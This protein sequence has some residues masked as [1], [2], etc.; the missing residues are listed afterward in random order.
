MTEGVGLV[1]VNT[2]FKSRPVTGVE[3][4]AQELL[5]RLPSFLDS[6]VVELAPR[7]GADG[8]RGHLWEQVVLPVRFR[9]S[10][11]AV[12]VSLCNFGPLSVSPQVVLLHDV[13]PFLVPDSFGARYA[14]LA[15]TLQ[16]RLAR[17]ATLAT[18]SEQSRRDIAS[19]LGLSPDSIAI[20]PPAAAAP[21]RR[22]DAGPD[23]T[24]CLFVGG[25][26]TRKNLPFLLELW[27]LVHR[28]TGAWLDVVARSRSKTLRSGQSGTSEGIVWHWDIDDAT[29]AG[30]YRK[31]KLIVSPSRYEG[32]GLPLLEAMSCGTPFLSTSV[33]A[34]PEL[35]VDPD[36]QLLPLSREQWVDR[37]VQMLTRDMSDLRRASHA[38]AAEWTWERSTQQLAA[39]VV[40]A[41]AAR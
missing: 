26:D 23:G 4:V 32:F 33:G 19:V 10:H 21:F 25:H 39:A 18:V 35:A 24:N 6:P 3:R 5:T 9:S 2:R 38:K 11:A 1:A 28:R 20:V 41:S 14:A 16:M 17:R 40:R 34:A 31:A 29:L 12:L 27:P 22:D 13:A 30:L 37:L 8:M 15:K 7:R 36:Q